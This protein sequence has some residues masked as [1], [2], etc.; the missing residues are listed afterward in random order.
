[1]KRLLKARAAVITL[2]VTLAL[3]IYSQ[4]MKINDLSGLESQVE[5]S[6]TSI[7]TMAKWGFAVVFVITGIFVAWEIASNKNN[8]KEH[9]IAWFIALVFYF[10]VIFV[11]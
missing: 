5:K 2:L 11:V 4:G 7:V 3:P 6:S 9:G 8:A 10:I 1:M